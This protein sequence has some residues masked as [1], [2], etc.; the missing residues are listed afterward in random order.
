MSWTTS[1]LGAS[2]LL[3]MLVAAGCQQEAWDLPDDVRW[4]SP[5]FVYHTRASDPSAC[6]GVL[7]QL[8][9]HF[10]S[11][12]DALELPWPDGRVIDYYKL[13]DRADYGANS[14]C[15]PTFSACTR[16]QTVR[17]WTPFHQHELIHAY[18]G[19]LGDPPPLLT[20]GVAQALSCGPRVH[21]APSVGWE[22][23][24]TARTQEGAFDETSLP[25]TAGP[26]FVAQLI[27]SHG[28]A[29][30]LRLYGTVPFDASA[31]EFD[32]HFRAVYGRPM[33]EA[34][35]DALA[36][37]ASNVGCVHA[38]ECTRLPASLE[39]GPLRLTETCEDG[40][41]FVTFDVPEGQN[42][43]WSDALVPSGFAIK[44]CESPRDAQV[45]WLGGLGPDSEAGVASVR[46]GR[47]FIASRLGSG[48]V[49][50]QARTRVLTTDCSPQMP[51][52]VPAVP[53]LAVAIPNGARPWHLTLRHTGPH[54]VRALVQ[55]DGGVLVERCAR[56]GENCQP[57][58]SPP[59][60][61]ML[62]GDT[63]LRITPPAGTGYTTVQLQ[64]TRLPQR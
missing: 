62:S 23:A 3:A 21:L 26:W 55:P 24:V 49:T 20:E 53:L 45:D 17:T 46:T 4:I 32:R 31:A 44:S 47:H 10:D 50:L 8:E 22:A 11:V 7:A 51:F 41:S 12:Q 9:R 56:C 36:A 18:L 64:Q 43:I 61:L 16:G 57:F 54:L 60:D 63:A 27:H 6:A 13:V 14:R 33:A 35:Q 52:V 48:Q 39:P 38:W 37:G 59:G 2:A 19:H 1:E 28:A 25:Y 58:P 42:L 30:F 34:W 40:P 15:P 5:H 29:S